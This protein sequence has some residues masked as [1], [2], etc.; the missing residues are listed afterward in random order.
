M[1][2]MIK[3]HHFRKTYGSQLILD[4]PE[5]L[6][7]EGIHWFKG[8][9]G[10]GKTTFFKSLAGLIPFKGEIFLHDINMRKEA[11]LYRKWVNYSEAEPLYPQFLTARDLIAFCAEA[12][13]AT[14]EQIKEL[15]SRLEI[16]SYQ[17]NAIGTYS[18][19]MLKKLSL[20]MGFLGKP[21]LIILD[22]PLTTIDKH[23]R[24]II[25]QLIM[26]YRKNGVSFLLSSHQDF[27]EDELAVSS[28]YHVGEQ[29]I[30]KETSLKNT[31]LGQQQSIT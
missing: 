5:L 28:L 13:E 14:K 21:K 22:E 10:S 24:G 1:T 20:L 15:S 6:I 2:N 19:G 12:K 8:A 4:I 23:A 29:G 16:E 11:V 7:P 25:S 26:E 18:S 17:D 27:E 9:N 30:K 3:I 31:S